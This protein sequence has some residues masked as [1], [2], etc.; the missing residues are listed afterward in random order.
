[1]AKKGSKPGREGLP[2]KSAESVCGGP[3]DDNPE[4][5]LKPGKGV[6]GSSKCPRPKSK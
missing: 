1:M 2:Y 3:P 5:G 6:K 4:K